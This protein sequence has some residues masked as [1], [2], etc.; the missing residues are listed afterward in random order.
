MWAWDSRPF[1][2]QSS[3]LPQHLPTSLYPPIANCVWRHQ[4]SPP[5]LTVQEVTEGSLCLFTFTHGRYGRSAGCCVIVFTLERFWRSQ[6]LD[7]WAYLV[8]LRS[9]RRMKNFFLVIL[10]SR[11]SSYDGTMFHVHPVINKRILSLSYVLIRSLWRHI[12]YTF[13][14]NTRF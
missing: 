2:P 7:I 1:R 3:L 4:R 9:E 10:R 11:E 6:G 12:Y 8:L 5:A 13:I 14:Y